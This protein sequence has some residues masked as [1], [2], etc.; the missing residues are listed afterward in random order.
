MTLFFFAFLAGVL[1]I[2]APCVLPML[3]IILG[4][5]AGKDTNK[6]S[7]WIITLSLGASVFAF[8]L[9]LKVST[10]FIDIPQSFWNWFTAIILMF[11][12]VWFLF[13]H[14][15][16][17]LS[18][19]LGLGNKTQQL[20]ANSQNKK[21]VTRDV[22]M[23]AALGPVFSSCSPTYFFI[24][25][26]VLPQSFGV[27]IIYLLA[28]IAGLVLMLTA[29][30][31]LGQKI[32]GKLKWATDANGWFKRGLGVVFIFV[33]ISIGFG[34]EKKFEAALLDTGIYEFINLEDEFLREVVEE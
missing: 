32:I 21:G 27:G 25:A 16:E 1:T 31:L 28:Y 19:K 2:L 29:V 22:L 5:A 9:L 4:G 13:P 11:L 17:K 18:F 24:I 15:W 26:T 12:G 7:V 23:G 30:A 20:L 33:G 3:P 14:A 6:K 8:T 34:Y 10:L